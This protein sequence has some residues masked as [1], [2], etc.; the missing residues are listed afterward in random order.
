MMED[1]EP[2][3]VRMIYERLV[4]AEKTADTTD[5]ALKSSL[6]QFLRSSL[7]QGIIGSVTRATVVIS[8]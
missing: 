3:L 5:L 8:D 4:E 7:F 2:V 1:C 6:A